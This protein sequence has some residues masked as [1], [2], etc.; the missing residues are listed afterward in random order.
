MS[1]ALYTNHIQIKSNETNNRN[2]SGRYA[3]AVNHSADSQLLG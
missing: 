2:P 3:S 1:G